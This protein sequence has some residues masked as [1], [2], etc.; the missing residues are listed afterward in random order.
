MI[1]WVPGHRDIEGNELA[2]RLATS[3]HAHGS[4]TSREV[5]VLDLKPALRKTLKSHWQHLWDS[6]TQ[7][8]L[9][10]VKPDLGNWPQTSKTRRTEVTLCRLRIGHTYSTHA[11]LL[12]GGESPS[13]DR[14]GEPLTVL[15]I[16]LQ[17]TQLEPYRRKHFPLLYKQ[18]IPLHPAMF[19]GKEPFIKHASLL[20][21]LKDVRSF[22]VICPGNP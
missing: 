10:M 9:H 4:D 6:Q 7:N 20:E 21:F 18:Q 19:L 17:C 12:S 1:C 2:D 14:C 16:L 15:H 13:C 3:A 22:N 8:K 11:H 5:P